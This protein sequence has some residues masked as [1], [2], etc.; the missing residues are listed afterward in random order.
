MAWD[1][2]K[3]DY[4]NYRAE[5]AKLKAKTS[6]QLAMERAEQ[7]KAA[8]WATYKRNYERQYGLPYVHAN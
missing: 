2:Q 3:F 7:V 1:L 5:F 4:K 8:K 6:F